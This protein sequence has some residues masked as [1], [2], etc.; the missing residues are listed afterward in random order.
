MWLCVV[1][2][3][4][5]N[6]DVDYINSQLNSALL[7]ELPVPLNE[8]I[9]VNPSSLFK[10]DF[11]GLSGFGHRSIKQSLQHI[12]DRSFACKSTKNSSLNLLD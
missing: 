11:V 8:V 3:D 12:N 6:K 5:R 10:L 9:L 1:D 2:P 4:E 7:D